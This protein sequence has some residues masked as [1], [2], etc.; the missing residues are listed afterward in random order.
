MAEIRIASFIVEHNIAITAVDHIRYWVHKNS[1]PLCD[2]FR[3]TSQLLPRLDGFQRENPQQ[4]FN[5]YLLPSKMTSTNILSSIQMDLRNMMDYKLPEIYSTFSA[6]AFAISK[7]LDTVCADTSK[8]CI[9]TDSL[10]VLKLL[11]SNLTPFAK[12][13]PIVR[14]IKTKL[15]IEKSRGSRIVF[16]WTK[17][18]SGI[19]HNEVVDNLAKAAVNNIDLST[20]SLCIS[21]CINLVKKNTRNEWATIY[22]QYCTNTLTQYARIQEDL[23][24]Q[25]WFMT[26][27]YQED[28]L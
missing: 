5:D 7:A 1:P 12:I 19:T 4:S 26:S 8:I 21:D 25:P 14:Q 28:M 20:Q 24:K 2:A 13:N 18:H 16:I 3:E 17:A 10:S 22:H 27:R 11:E 15:Q 6:E 9:L 23:P